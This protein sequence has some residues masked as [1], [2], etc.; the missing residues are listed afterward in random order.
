ML[1]LARIGNRLR[2]EPLRHPAHSRELRRRDHKGELVFSQFGF[3]ADLASLF[4]VIVEDE[5]AHD[6]GTEVGKDRVFDAP[7]IEVLSA[8]HS[9]TA[10]LIDR[11]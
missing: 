6:P 9:A 2:P 4:G 3:H 11:P 7:V 8:D 1:L 10:P 5:V